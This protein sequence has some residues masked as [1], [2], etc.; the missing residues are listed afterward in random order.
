MSTAINPWHRRLGQILVGLPL[1]SLTLAAVAWLRYGID[2]PWFDDWRG[3]AAGTIDSLELRY[4]FQPMNDTMSPVGLALDA[5]A[6]R[7]LDGNSIAYQFLSMVTVLG[8][9]LLLQWKLLNRALG[10]A[11][12]VAVCFLFTVL[13]LQPNSYWGLENLAYYQALPLVFILW[14]LWLMSG[15]G[16]AWRGPAVGL[17]GLL[18]GFTYISGAFGGLALGIASLALTYRLDSSPNRRHLM[19]DWCWFTAASA[20]TVAVQFYFSVLKSRGTHVGIPLALPTESSFWFFYLGK[21]GRSLL[22]PQN[23]PRGIAAD[24]RAG[25]RHRACKR[26]AVVSARPVSAGSGNDTGKAGGIHLSSAGRT[27][28]RVPDA[29]RGR[30]HQLPAAGHAR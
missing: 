1:L 12:Q 2:M 3:Y 28:C 4:L 18:A 7:F 29:R 19:R 26:N 21:L 25:M 11:W 15:P 24:H 30:P 27:R 13:M 23:R 14:A 5:L 20:L 22:L 6:Q 8:S 16:S 9:L 17:L 10:S